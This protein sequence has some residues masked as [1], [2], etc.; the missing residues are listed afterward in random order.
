MNRIVDRANAAAYARATCAVEGTQQ[1]Q[2][3]ADFVHRFVEGELTIEEAIAQARKEY[4]LCAQ[5][6]EHGMLYYRVGNLLSDAKK[7]NLK[8]TFEP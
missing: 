2:L 7:W 6:D 4:G 5:T 3:A 8:P 1:T